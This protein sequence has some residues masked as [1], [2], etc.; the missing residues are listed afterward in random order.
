MTLAL[1]S[2]R[3]D[4]RSVELE[5]DVIAALSG[6]PPNAATR[7]L[8]PSTAPGCA[9]VARR[10]R[11]PAG[12]DRG[13]VDSGDFTLVIGPN[14]GASSAGRWLGRFAD[15]FGP[16]GEEYYAWLSGA[17]QDAEAA[18]P[19]EVVYLPGTPRSTNVIVRPTIGTHEIVVSGRGSAEHQ[20]DLTD[21]LV[22]HDGTKLYL[23]SRSQGLLLRPTARHMLNHH[24]APPVCQFL[25][26]VGQG[27]TAE[28]T[29]FDW[30]QA[31]SLPVLP[32]VQVGRTVLAPARW[33]VGVPGWTATGGVDRAALDAA[34]DTARNRWGL[35]DRV[36][37]TVADNRLLLDLSE[38]DDREQLRREFKNSGGAM[39][40]Q[41]ALPDVGDAWLPG[42]DGRYLTELVISLVRRPS[43]PA[44]AVPV[45]A[46][47]SGE[48]GR[49][50]RTSQGDRHPARQNCVT[51]CGYPAATGCS[52]SSTH[53]T[54]N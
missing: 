37:A 9:V 50:L 15:L 5:P 44:E 7:P 33:L 10:V 16:T 3:D 36:Y 51:G 30:G 19:A 38:A 22:G 48:V 24:G 14:L 8:T 52:P 26:A 49:C 28:F 43:G 17:E 11:L 46:P 6:W 23:R 47:A 4:R 2:L 13:A 18:V 27:L 35:P 31:E 25:D 34:L 54:S 12:S 39:R 40:L 53:R 41:E 1:E 42:P 20:L 29:G 45:A 32:R 21:L